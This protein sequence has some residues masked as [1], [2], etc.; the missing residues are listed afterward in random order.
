M[1]GRADA[2]RTR[3]AVEHSEKWK[4]LTLAAEHVEAGLPVPEES[5]AAVA[6]LIRAARPRR[7]GRRLDLEAE[8][9][10][11]RAVAEHLRRGLSR[12]QAL[13]AAADQL[14]IKD[15]RRIRRMVKILP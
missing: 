5:R 4:E 14:G 9:R 8:A 12:N 3:H 1:T 2:V 15:D 13:A 10:A 11:A 6:R 7:K